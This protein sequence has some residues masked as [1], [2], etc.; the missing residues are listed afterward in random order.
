M[1]EANPIEPR[2]KIRLFGGCKFQCEGND[3]RLETAKTGAL[4]A[5]VTFRGVFYRSFAVMKKRPC[6]LSLSPIP[7]P[8]GQTAF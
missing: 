1:N 5:Y 4:P 7:F 6:D 2:L 8:Q 3:V